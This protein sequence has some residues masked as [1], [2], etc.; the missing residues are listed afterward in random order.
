[1]TLLKLESLGH[2]I[3]AVIGSV[4]AICWFV[5]TPTFE[6]TKC[7]ALHEWPQL[8]AALQHFEVVA[9]GG[10]GPK[11]SLRPPRAS[12]HRPT[13]TGTRRTR[14][15]RK[16][17]L[18]GSLSLSSPTPTPNQKTA[19]FLAP[20]RPEHPGTAIRSNAVLGIPQPLP[21]VFRSLL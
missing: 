1:M 18:R 17:S 11:R 3:I 8:R 13:N 19:P 16:S 2:K 4:A 5:R 7:C 9:N 12:P 6:P 15:P 20:N 14:G 10:S 21:V